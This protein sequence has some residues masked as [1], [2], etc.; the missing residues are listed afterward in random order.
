MKN[1]PLG[2]GVTMKILSAVLALAAA[3]LVRIPGELRSSV[4]NLIRELYKMH[5]MV[6]T[7]HLCTLSGEHF[8]VRYNPENSDSAWLVLETAEKAYNQLAN[9]YNFR[10]R[11]IPVIIYPSRSA[12]NA[13]FGWS[14]SESAMGV[15]WAGVIRVLAPEAWIAENI[16][17]V[18]MRSGPMAHELTH[19]ILDALTKGNIPRWLTEG[20]AQYEEARINGPCCAGL[21]DR[22][23]AGKRYYSFVELDGGFDRLPDQSLAYEQSLWAVEYIVCVYGED[24]IKRILTALAAGKDIDQA[25]VHALGVGLKDFEND[26]A[27][28]LQDKAKVELGRVEQEFCAS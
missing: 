10:A 12:L 5:A 3:L 13:C 25:L 21:E 9:K 20:L 14:A 11:G 23:P 19:L 1:Y 8:V 17:D 27:S 4:Y 18:F 15:Y 22:P 7:R 26:W 2:P 16:E 28:W 6:S 24:S